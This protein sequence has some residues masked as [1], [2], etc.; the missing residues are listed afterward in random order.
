MGTITQDRLSGKILL[1]FTPKRN[2]ALFNAIVIVTILISEA[3]LK[4]I[5][6]NIYHFAL[7]VFMYGFFFFFKPRDRFDK[8]IL[9]P[10]SYPLLIW[11]AY[12]V[13]LSNDLFEEYP[14]AKFAGMFVGFLYTL[15]FHAYFLKTD[16]K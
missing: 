11:T 9:W 12:Y 1:L 10:V 7:W 2:F 8:Y 3:R 14:L 16:Q 4:A 13:F 5:S 6:E 15:G